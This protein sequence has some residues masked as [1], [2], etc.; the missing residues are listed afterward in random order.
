[1][2]PILCVI[3]GIK[4]TGIALKFQINISDELIP[5]SFVYGIKKTKTIPS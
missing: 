4:V 3:L 2:N 5:I 1:M